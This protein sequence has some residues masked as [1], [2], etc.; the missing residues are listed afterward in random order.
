[1]TD[2][3]TLR[4]PEDAYDI[5]KESKR[6][7][8]TWGEFLQRCSDNPPEIREFVEAGESPDDLRA[9][10]VSSDIDP[11]KL[12]E[13]LDVIESAAK[14]ATQAAQSAEQSVEELQR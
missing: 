11:D 8:E 6:E 9:G 10:L 13:Q 3:K 5:A 7:K 12:S 1:M 2:Y 14:E 4:V